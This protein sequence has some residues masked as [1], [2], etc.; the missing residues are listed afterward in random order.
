MTFAKTGDWTWTVWRGTQA[1]SPL[2]RESAVPISTVEHEG[3]MRGPVDIRPERLLQIIG[4]DLMLGTDQARIVE[5]L[6]THGVPASS[7]LLAQ[8]EQLA[9]MPMVQVGRQMALKLRKRNWLLET[10]F[11]LADDAGNLAKVPRVSDLSKDAFFQEYYARNLP[12]IVAGAVADWPAVARWTPDYLKTHIGDQIVQVQANRDKNPDYEIYK[13]RH[14]RQ[15]T[16]ADFIDQ[17]SG[18]NGAN[19]NLYMTA[20]NASHNDRALSAVRG[21]MGTIERY[22]DPA[23]DGRYG[24]MWIGPA[25]T[26]TPM[27]HDLTNNLLVQVAGR[28]IIKLIPAAQV[29]VMYNHLHVFSAVSD[30][31][32]PAFDINRFPDFARARV[33]DVTLVPGDALF[34]PIGW[35]HQV[36]SLDFSVTL[37]FTNFHRN[38]AY[39]ESYPS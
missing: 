10:L 13:D 2:S 4:E 31:E 11:R 34:I 19:N 7:D 36:R 37:T 15:M 25:G 32:N 24:M 14:L 39:H 12:V 5:K 20:Y 16:F 23:S 1:T 21:D 26:I 33:L 38:N 29:D 27:H 17:I 28:K 8:I 6:S 22:L 30:I 35:W 18:S 9:A 3:R